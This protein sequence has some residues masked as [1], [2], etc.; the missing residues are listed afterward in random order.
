MRA[1]REMDLETRAHLADLRRRKRG[2]PSDSEKRRASAEAEVAAWN[3]A[4]P[5]GTPVTVT[6][7]L[8][9]Q[10]ETKTRSVAWVICDHAS[11]MVDGISGGYLLARV[12]PR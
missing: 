11:V 2:I 3:A 4:H 5:V 8:G 7:D 10:V 12:R 6:L 1:K 9:E